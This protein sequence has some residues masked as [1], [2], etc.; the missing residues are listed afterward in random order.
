MANNKPML[1]IKGLKKYF[2]IRAGVFSRVSGYVRAVDDISLTIY[3]GE[4]YALVGESGCGKSTTGHLIMKMLKPTTGEVIFEEQEIFSLRKREEKSLR[5]QVQLIFQDPYSSLNPRMTVGESIGEALEVH[6][7]AKGEERQAKVKA[8][9]E[10]C[11]LAGYHYRRYPHEFSGGQR[12]RIVIARALVLEPRFIVADEPV[13]A[14]DVSI[15][16]QIINLLKELQSK[17]G[18]TYLFISHDLSVVKH[19]ADR[20]AVMYLGS[21]VEESTKS[22]FYERP[23]HPYTQALLSAVPE[24]D[25][26]SRKKRIILKG[27]VPSPANPPAGCRFHTRCQYCMEI[28]VQERPDLKEAAPG[29][30]VACHLVHR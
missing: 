1:S 28:C 23:L 21:L 3:P 20:I 19:M 6:G 4:V 2:P 14:L 18:L 17:M 5:K 10:L 11:G 13:S 9:L 27:D 8:V 26:S 22:Q 12:Q 15:Q 7:I 30:L 16:S 29:H 25:I 24:W